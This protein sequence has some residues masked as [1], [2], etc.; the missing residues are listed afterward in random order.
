MIFPPN[1]R[2]QNST[3]T[4]TNLE[5]TFSS[6]WFSV[7]DQWSSITRLVISDKSNVF[8][9]EKRTQPIRSFVS[10]VNNC[11]PYIH[12]QWYGY[13]VTQRN[14]HTD[15]HNTHYGGGLAL[16]NSTLG[17]VK[18]G[19]H[20]PCWRPKLTAWVYGWPVYITR[21]L[22]PSTQLMETGRPCWLV[23]ETGHPS[24]QAINSGCQLGWWKLGFS[25][26]TGDRSFAGIPS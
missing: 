10:A 6:V 8:N 22:G 17:P 16:I 26:G 13:I 24:T 21:Q 15:I 11:Y 4:M 18:P 20:Y 19:F 3:S 7:I 9:V 1:Q 14:T 25:T 5:Q 12:T 2:R 23:M